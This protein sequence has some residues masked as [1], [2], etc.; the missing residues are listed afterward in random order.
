MMPP[1][2]PPPLRADA[3]L[4]FFY[5]DASFTN[6]QGTIT[7]HM[8]AEWHTAPL[9]LMLLFSRACCRRRFRFS[10]AAPILRRQYAAR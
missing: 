2:L 7:R 8:S 3:A 4:R 1:P 10:A 5:A 9:R 6:K